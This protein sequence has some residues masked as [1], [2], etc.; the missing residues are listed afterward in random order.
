[1][2]ILIM[3]LLQFGGQI[4]AVFLFQYTDP[5]YYAD[6]GGLDISRQNYLDTGDFRLNGV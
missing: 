1:M 3:F 6:N 4:S 5:T 2:Q